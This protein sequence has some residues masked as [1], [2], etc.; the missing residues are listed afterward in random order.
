MSIS[1]L[2]ARSLALLAA[3]FV[4]LG[5]AVASAQPLPAPAGTPILEIS[6]RI[7]VTNGDARARFDLAM[8]EALGVSRTRTTTAWTNGPQD[9]EGVSLKALLERVGAFGDRI[10]AVAL[11]DYK[12]EIPVSDFARWPVIL[13]WRQNGQLMRVRDKG[14]LWIVYPQDDFP[15]LNNKEAQGKWTWQLKEIRVK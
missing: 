9:F 8:L 1:R 11:N 6:G 14:P 10:E 3:A 7:S 5:L 12:V 4:V 13:A 15:A 2:A